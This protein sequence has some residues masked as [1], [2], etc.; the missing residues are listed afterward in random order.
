VCQLFAQD[1]LTNGL[2]AYYPFISNA[3]D[4]SG[5][6]RDGVVQ[7]ATLDADRLWITSNAYR[8]DDLDD[9]I[10]IGESPVTSS[11]TISA[12]ILKDGDSATHDQIVCVTNVGGVYL[13]IY[14]IQ[15]P[16]LKN[17]IDFGANYN[18]LDR[19][20]SPNPIPLNTWVHVV[21]S[22]DGQS[23]RLFQDGQLV[24]EAAR[25]GGFSSGTMYIGRDGGESTPI[26]VFRGLIDDVRIYD[27]ALATNEVMQLYEYE[28]GPRIDLV[29]AVKPAFS[30][31]RVGTNYQLQLSG[32][33]LT[34]TNH[35]PAFTATNTAMVYAQYWEVENW[36]R[37]FFRLKVSP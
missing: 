16:T 7:G 25:S 17:H 33:L 19:Y 36:D 1:P 21:A 26:D 23:V 24:L 29:K 14:P 2:V 12:W 20:F 31:L 5:H 11:L 15:N 34:W 37:L 30:D 18:P 4:A 8:F 13:N 35:G 10:R 6:S 3:N 32:D 22:Y 9:G 28:K 27:R